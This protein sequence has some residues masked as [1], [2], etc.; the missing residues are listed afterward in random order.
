[1]FVL[2][3][4][5]VSSF[6]A[7]RRR[8]ISQNLSARARADGLGRRIFRAISI[9]R[10]HI[11]WSIVVLTPRLSMTLPSASYHCVGDL[12]W[13]MRAQRSTRFP[14]NQVYGGDG[15][16]RKESRRR[17]PRGS[18]PGDNFNLRAFRESVARKSRARAK[19]RRSIK[20]RDNSPSRLLA[21]E[22][23]VDRSLGVPRVTILIE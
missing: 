20:Q 17:I 23:G 3:R 21:R 15:A 6:K 8:T 4:S 9:F 18:C 10:Y 1:M 19:R 5:D 14:E 2:T 7:S 22:G 11:I 12:H 16:A 13:K